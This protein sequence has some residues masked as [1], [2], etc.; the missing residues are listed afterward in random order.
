M[1]SQRRQR[2]CQLAGRLRRT[3]D[4]V[5]DL[6]FGYRNQTNATYTIADTVWYDLSGDGIHQPDGR[7]GDPAKRSP[8][9]GRWS[10]FCSF[11]R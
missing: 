1:L 9:C 8:R 11:K 5:A 6:D 10:P 2:H 7:D 4:I 3:S